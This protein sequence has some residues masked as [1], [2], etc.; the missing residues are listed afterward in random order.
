MLN[1]AINFANID[2]SSIQPEIQF[3]DWSKNAAAMHSFIQG[4]QKALTDQANAYFEKGTNLTT[5]LKGGVWVA[6]DALTNPTQ[7]SVSG[8]LDQA[9]T[10]FDKQA[11]MGLINEA[12]K[13]NNNYI[14]FLP[15]G[16]HIGN[17]GSGTVNFDQHSCETY[18]QGNSDWNGKIYSCCNCGPSG[19]EG[20]AMFMV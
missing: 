12:W 11:V 2:G 20:M 8:V 5:I 14:V 16:N 4:A 19:N 18:F 6:S 1:G 10:W 13:A 7:D 9:A 3:Q 15:Y 17:Y